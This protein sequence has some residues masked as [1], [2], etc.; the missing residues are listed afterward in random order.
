MNTI[1]K[2]SKPRNNET[3]AFQAETKE[4]L[5]LMVNSLYTHKE[6][7]LRELIS[8]ASD[9]LDKLHF[10]S[11]T[12]H[13]LL[14]EDENLQINIEIDNGK[15]QLKISDNGIGMT[16][17]QVVNNIGTIAKSDSKNFIRRLKEKKDL[18]LIGRFGVGFYSAFMVA[19][20]VTLITRGAG[21]K[22]GVKWESKGDGRYSIEKTQKAKR[23]TEITLELKKEF[24]IVETAEENFLNQYTIQNLIQKYSNYIKFPI[25]MDFYKED[26][27]NIK[28]ETTDNQYVTTIENKVLNSMTPIWK[29]SRRELTKDDYFQFYKQHFQDWNEFADVI[30]FKAEGKVEFTVLLFIPSRAPSDL[31]EKDYSRGVHLYSNHVLVMNN[32]KELLPSYLRFVRGLIDSPDFKLNI[33]R[34]FIQQNAQLK[35]IGKSLEQRILKA[36]KNMLKNDR[37]KY[38]S[39]WNELGK[40]VK[41]GIYIQYDNKSKLQD[42]L[43]FP[44]SSGN[45]EQTTLKEYV[46]RMLKGQK[47]IYYAAAKDLNTIQRMPQLEAFKNNG[48]EIL[49]FVDKIDEFLVENLHE[50]QGKKLKSITRADVDLYDIKDAKNK[51][52][53]KAKAPQKDFENFLE[54]IGNH[55]GSK[56]KEVRI[57]DRLVSS[58]VCFVNDSSGTTFNMEQL[59]KGA[60]QPAAPATKI[61]EINPKHRLVEILKSLYDKDKDSS[62]VKQIS[63]ILFNQAL[64]I[65]GYDLEDPVAYG[66][67][68]NELLVKNYS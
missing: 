1:L 53:K 50:Y 3:F 62:E 57:S 49:Y 32:C 33:T 22:I 40:S 52:S 20:K 39:F 13:E 10:K 66:S 12:D 11:L 24:C 58:P 28:E 18:D 8:N 21:R 29:K 48:V 19:D 60:N 68:I 63:E 36:L 38:V 64:L 2:K 6:V 30:H 23:G 34:E 15:R 67:L 42:L 65:E 43:L 54:E 41:E 4:L 47:E 55:L 61:L 9:A 45:E 27:S 7:F 31:Y 35:V 59:L 14:G 56:V 46:S 16:R 37:N 17:Q 44:S 51:K 5:N 25:N 26:Y